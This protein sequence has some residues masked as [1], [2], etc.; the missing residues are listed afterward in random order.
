[1]SFYNTP[2]WKAKR[3][4][5][6]RRDNYECRE[7]KRYGKVTAANTVHHIF[8]LEDYYDL[9]LVNLNLYSCCNAC[10]NSFHD[11]FTN[12]ITLKGKQLQERFRD[13]IFDPPSVE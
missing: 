4:V 10:H 3:Q 5:I 12:E 2:R 13:K 1:M 6:L 8:P 7:C 11:R 9:R